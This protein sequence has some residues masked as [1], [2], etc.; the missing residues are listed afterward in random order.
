MTAKFSVAP[1][2]SRPQI[3]CG[4][5]GCENHFA[6]PARSRRLYCSEE[7]RRQVNSQRRA[8]RRTFERSLNGPNEAHERADKAPVVANNDLRATLETAT[9]TLRELRRD[10]D[11]L[12]A[13]LVEITEARQLLKEATASSETTSCYHSPRCQSI[14]GLLGVVTIALKTNRDFIMSMSDRLSEDE[15]RGPGAAT[16][17]G[18]S[19]IAQL[20]A[21][22]KVT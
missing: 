19:A 6:R 21:M 10:R 8:E 16:S 3:T 15:L 4:R 13:A 22:L 20:A 1:G 7:C 12:L 18:I 14:D 11:A 9:A 17:Q 2:V 5:D